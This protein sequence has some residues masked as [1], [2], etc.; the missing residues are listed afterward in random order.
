MGASFVKVQSIRISAQL[1]SCGRSMRA[2]RATQCRI[3][4]NRSGENQSSSSRV[5]ALREKR[6]ETCF[7]NRRPENAIR[8][9]Q[10][11]VNLRA[12][13]NVAQCHAPEMRFQLISARK[14]PSVAMR[15]IAPFLRQVVNRHRASRVE[16]AEE[17]TTASD[18][19]QRFD[20]LNG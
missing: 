9:D 11:E 8:H 1:E 10:L 17:S 15:S 16:S 20:K 19:S 2:G 7:I 4:S 5:S 6:A 12:S 14:Q 3:S 18:V 13:G